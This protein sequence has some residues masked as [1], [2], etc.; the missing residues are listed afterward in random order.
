MEVKN[1]DHL[2][3][4]ALKHQKATSKTAKNIIF[5]EMEA[6]FREEVQK[7]IRIKYSNWHHQTD[8]DDLYQLCL[9]GIEKN[10]VNFDATKAH[11]AAFVYVIIKRRMITEFKRLHAKK[12]KL[13]VSLD[14]TSQEEG[15]PNLDEIVYEKQKPHL[16]KMANEEEIK[17]IT[18]QLVARLSAYERKIFHYYYMNH[19]EDYLEVAKMA[20]IKASTNRKKF[21]AVD[22]ALS[23]IRVKAAKLLNDKGN[24]DFLIEKG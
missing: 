18:T 24:P 19:C 10:V 17:K 1:Q 21:K 23:R 13:L 3:E 5:N 22:N 11:Y 16:T 7:Y 15:N 4:L 9:I 14:T 8:L 12:Y 2:Q 20:G 6:L